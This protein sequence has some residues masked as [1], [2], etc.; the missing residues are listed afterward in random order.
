MSKYLIRRLDGTTEG[1][2]TAAELRTLAYEGQLTDADQISPL[3]ET[4][5]VSARKV[6]GIREILEM[7]APPPAAPAEAQPPVNEGDNAPRADGPSR[8]SAFVD[9]SGTGSNGGSQGEAPPPPPP[10][11]SS[12]FATPQ[13][14]RRPLAAGAT[15]G[16]GFADRV[17]RG[18][19]GFARAISVLVILACSLALVGSLVLAAYSLMPVEPDATS[20]EVETP[21]LAAFV[22][23]CRA[24]ETR[25]P[26]D[27]TTN[28]DD[29]RPRQVRARNDACAP[30]RADFEFVLRTL[31]I[32]AE[33]E[34]VLCRKALALPSDYRRQFAVGLRVLAEDYRKKQPSGARC[35][36]ADAVNWY[37]ADFEQRVEAELAE[38]EL[39]ELAAAAEGARRG[40]RVVL[41]LSIAGGAGILLLAF[42]F[43]PLLIQI[44]RNT[45]QPLAR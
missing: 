2:Y 1:P 9:D 18:A 15:E 26:S 21:A 44:E 37:I 28:M 39:A 4:R 29:G 22:E 27:S 38:R 30:Y 19:F 13:H 8:V 17:L 41:G 31:Q 33:S 34:D 42:L 10:F 11:E 45:R 3:G 25:E 6:G 23:E 12:S 35:E 32:S 36:P 14:P 16:A 20:S 24:V 40:Q 7:L 43:L 5:W